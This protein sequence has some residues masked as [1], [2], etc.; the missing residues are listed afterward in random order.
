M[1]KMLFFVSFV[2]VMLA[3]VRPASAQT[4]PQSAELQAA[5]SRVGDFRDM[6][7]EF[8]AESYFPSDWAAAQS[9]YAKAGLLFEAPGANRDEAIAAMNLAADSFESVLDMTLSL[10]AQ[11]REDEIMAIRSGLMDNG[12][13]AFFP[14]FVGR[15]DLAALDAWDLYE[16]GNYR[17]A[18]ASAEKALAMF[19]VLETGF[20]AWQ[21]RR[22]IVLMGFSDTAKDLE[23]ADEIM[24]DAV[25]AY[26]DGNLS[27]AMENAL[28]ARSRYS[29]VVSS[30]W[31]GVAER[32]ASTAEAE[33]LAAVEMRANVAVKGI[34]EQADLVYVTAIDLLRREHY[35]EAAVQ[36]DKAT[37]LYTIAIS[38]TRQLRNVAA[39]AIMEAT[40]RIDGNAKGIL[41]Y[42]I[43]TSVEDGEAPQIETSRSI[44]E[45]HKERIRRL[46]D[47]I[48]AAREANANDN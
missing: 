17:E 47:M 31:A 21:T 45:Q 41:R 5:S 4:P 20:A 38:S 1:G 43:Q 24:G 16:A 28:E 34:F 18:R 37:S 30:G 46:E 15:A 44:L 8:G 36:F 2:A 22:E 10:Y 13:R 14:E 27:L 35:M 40:L 33:R 29:L 9:A 6:A 3:I 23:R 42:F 11:A 26:N 39:N 32:R 12:A 19:Q 25:R 7:A 48:R